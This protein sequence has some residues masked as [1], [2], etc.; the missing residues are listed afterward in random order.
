MTVNAT[1]LLPWGPSGPGGL[2][3]L[4]GLSLKG[5]VPNDRR[6]LA[7]VAIEAETQFLTHLLENLRKSMVKSLGSRQA[8]L[9]GYQSLA[10]QHLARAL[11]L[12]GGIGLAH[13][14][15]SDLG[16]RIPEA[17]KETVDD[18]PPHWGESDPTPARDLSV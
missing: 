3:P 8:D 1:G 2:S 11:T 12:G 13:R 5:Q 14:I 16:S 18:L 7:Q 4:H 10:D 17:Q 9:Q 15:Y 6:T